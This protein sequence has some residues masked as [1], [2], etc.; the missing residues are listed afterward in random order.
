M[1]ISKISENLERCLKFYFHNIISIKSKSQI[2]KQPILKR[3][4]QI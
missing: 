1:V 2:K 4:L 3:L